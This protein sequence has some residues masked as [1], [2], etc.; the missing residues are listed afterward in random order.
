MGDPL[1]FSVFLQPFFRKN[2]FLARLCFALANS[3]TR[4]KIYVMRYGKT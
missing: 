3:K 4:L 1:G 2:K